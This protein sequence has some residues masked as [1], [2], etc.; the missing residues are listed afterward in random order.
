LQTFLTPT[1]L[2]VAWDAV[3]PRA[4]AGVDGVD[5]RCFQA[6]LD[7]N[8]QPTL[9]DRALQRSIL[10]AVTPRV[11]CVLH[12]KVYGFR[13]GRSPRTA[14]AC[15]ARQLSGSG[16]GDLVRIDI[17]EFFDRL[18]HRQVLQTATNRWDDP[19]WLHLSSRKTL[20]VAP[21]EGAVLPWLGGLLVRQQ[22]SIRRKKVRTGRF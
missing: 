6:N 7:R 20:V 21:R 17:H 15:L 5:G 4:N 3:G 16:A 9:C 2:R 19:D 22:G 8:L 11:E 10:A 12:D 18:D 1:A 14:V 13:P